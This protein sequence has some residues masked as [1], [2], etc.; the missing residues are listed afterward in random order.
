MSE[1]EGHEQ[2]ISQ[3]SKDGKRKALIIGISKYDHSNKFTNLDF[4]E[5]DA[6]EVYNVL[7]ELKDQRYDI[8]KDALLVGRVEWS[9]MRDEI[10]NFFR[11][12]ALRPDDTL[13]FYFSGHGYLDK[14]TNQ[15]YLATS[16]IDPELPES[17]GI[18]F[19]ELTT[20]LKLSNSERI[21]A[22]LDCCYS[23]GLEIG[24]GGKGAEYE[25]ESAKAEKGS[26]MEPRL[27]R[28]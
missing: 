10:I 1:L 8:P 9:R 4:C 7:K 11:D 6:N 3:S 13:F 16:E 21:V 23:G 14:N 15:T 27:M 18:P 28:V 25:D 5:N 12:R 22:V 24:N 19:E 2:V 20:H 17:R 26:Q